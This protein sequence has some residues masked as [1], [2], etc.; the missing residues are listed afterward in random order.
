MYRGNDFVG[1]VGALV[2]NPC[3]VCSFRVVSGPFTQWT[4]VKDQR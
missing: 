3:I 2:L 4:M 1:G